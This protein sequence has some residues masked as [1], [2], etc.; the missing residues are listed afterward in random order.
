MKDRIEELLE[1]FNATFP[2]GDSYELA[3]FIYAHA[4]DDAYREITS[5]LNA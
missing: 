2:C 5:T 3:E 4:K 1:Q